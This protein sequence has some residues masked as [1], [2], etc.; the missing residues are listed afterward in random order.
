[1]S[2]SSEELD[3]ESRQLCPD[4]ACVGVLTEDGHCPVCGLGRQE[5]QRKSLEAT[6]AF[7]VVPNDDDSSPA[8]SVE[9][10]SRRLCPD[11][12]CTGLL[13]PDGRCKMCGAVQTA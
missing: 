9:F 8:E 12:A 7:S 13:G 5:A 1:M 3:L 10:D 6:P 2:S 11:G 4:G